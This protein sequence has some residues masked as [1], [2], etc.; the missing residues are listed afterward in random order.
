METNGNILGLGY[1]SMDYLCVVPRIPLD[2]KVQAEQTLEQGGGPAATAIY[3]AARLGAKTAFIGTVGDDQRG[4]VILRDLALA[5]I[6]TTGIRLRLG[7][8]SS[9][10]FCWIQADTGQRS[11]VW[12]HGSVKALLPEEVNAT[13]IRHAG[14]LHLDGHHTDAAVQ[15]AEIARNAGVAVMFDAGTLVSRTD[16]LLALADIVIASEKFA[17]HFTGNLAMEAAL[18]KLF[19][20]NTKFT[21]VTLGKNGSIGWDGKRFYRQAVFPVKTV[22]TTGAGDVFH[23][24]FAYRYVNGGNWQDCMRF[25]AAVSALKCTK[26]GGRAGIPTLVE[27]EHFL[28]RH[29]NN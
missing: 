7:A 1:C 22:D 4:Q 23:G 28:S 21:A 8:E 2:D 25:A 18:R 10:T 13:A 26:L 14:L 15:A 17:E 5:G 19:G 27:T 16:E 3:A 6:D 12:S 9:V 11:I 29:K 20:K 24:A